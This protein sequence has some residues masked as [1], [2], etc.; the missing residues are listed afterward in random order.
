MEADNE[1]F[2]QVA[3]FH[4]IIMLL[5]RLA[6]D[7]IIVSAII[8]PKFVIKQRKEFAFSLYL[9]N[10]VI[11]ALCYVI[12]HTELGW[13]AGIGLFAIFAMLRFRSEMLNLLD[14]TYL[15][16]IISIGF[17]N[18]SFNGSISFVEILILNVGLFGMIYTLDHLHAHTSLQ[19]K[20]IKYNNLELI[21]PSKKEELVNDLKIKTGL[22][23][24]KVMIDNINLDEQKAT[25][26][27]YYY[28]GKQK[29]NNSQTDHGF[30][31]KI[32]HLMKSNHSLQKS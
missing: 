26:R 10:F 15:L 13:T 24:E 14:M 4:R 21:K 23:I 30:L 25:V 6:L 31:H 3:D 28:D 11:F 16:A 2:M 1:I 20:K 32:A 17:V 18:A 22:K 7:L 29:S 9:F 8:I 19:S 5:V 12:L 27:I